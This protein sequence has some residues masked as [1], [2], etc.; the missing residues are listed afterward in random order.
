MDV[1]LMFTHIAAI[2]CV[3]QILISVFL[4]LIT[5][6]IMIVFILPIF[7]FYYW[8]QNDYR[9]VAREVKR[10]DSIARSPRY[11]HFKE[12]LQGLTV[13]R[14]FGSQKWFKEEFCNRLNFSQ[15]M[16]YNH[17]MVN[18]WFSVRVP[19]IGGLIASCTA[20]LLVWA[21]YKNLLSPGVCGLVL[22]YAMSFWRQLN[23]AIRIFS[24]IEAR[25]TSIERLQFLCELP[26]EQNNVNLSKLKI[27]SH[28]ESGNLEFKNLCV[29]YANH[30]PLVLENISFKVKAGE[31]VG[32][33]GRTGSGKSTLFQALYRFVD[34]ET[35]DITIGGLSIKEIDLFQLRRSLAIIP[36]DPTL[37]LGTIRSN[38]D[39]YNEYT[40][41][42]IEMVLHKTCL[43]SFINQLP[44]GLNSNVI[45]NGN[46]FSQGQ[47]QLLCLARAL[48]VKAKVLILDEA[49]ASVDIQTDN[50]I[51][52]IL[53]QELNGVTLLIIAHRLETIKNCDQ[54]IRLNN[55][56]M[57]I[58]KHNEKLILKNTLEMS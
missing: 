36:Q 58:V 32:I 22:I 54:I 47:R 20:I 21:S 7:L 29:R 42:A 39:R 46:N 56:K 13:L 43:W 26:P 1:H 50:L 33:I 16:F 5:L 8:I 27:Q 4:I 2:D 51:Q 31:R 11:A 25:M 49:T 40:D 30:L 53:N 37:F 38:L 34:I 24:D 44:L 6:P 57:S 19:L 12:T 45:E 55:G 28:I 23:W 14:A 52:Q 17:Y 3:V 18:R 48:L 9:Q 10:L 15:K 35:G 41:L